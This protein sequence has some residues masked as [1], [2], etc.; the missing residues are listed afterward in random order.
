LKDYTNNPEDQ[1]RNRIMKL[2]NNWLINQL[3]GAESFLR[4]WKY[5]QLVKKFPSVYGTRRF[6][7]VFRRYRH[8]PLS[9]A[10]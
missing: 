3:P 2:D 6:I 4:T 7:A 9:W 10:K 1:N 5:T 8:R